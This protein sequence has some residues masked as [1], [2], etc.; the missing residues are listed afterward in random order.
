MPHAFSVCLAE[1]GSAVL[2]SRKFLRILAVN[3]KRR[4]WLATA[5]CVNLRSNRFLTGWLH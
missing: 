5:S 4:G 2:D 3:A 1:R